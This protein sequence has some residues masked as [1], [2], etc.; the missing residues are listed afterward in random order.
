MKDF[1]KFSSIS[2]LSS[3]VLTSS[4]KKKTNYLNSHHFLV[5]AHFLKL[6]IC[7]ILGQ[8]VF[9]ILKSHFSEFSN[10]GISIFLYFLDY[11]NFYNS[12]HFWINM[13]LK[14]NLQIFRVHELQ[15]HIKFPPLSLPVTKSGLVMLTQSH[16]LQYVIQT[17]KCKT[18]QLNKPSSCLFM[19][20]S[21][22]TR[23]N[24]IHIPERVISE[25]YQDLIDFKFS[26]TFYCIFEFFNSEFSIQAMK[27]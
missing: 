26:Q 11:A 14:L 3:K 22:S 10:F 16:I 24:I 27:P 25:L 15:K 18:C 13:E 1:F 12:E 9:K 4:I 19:R 2:F 21:Y 5:F 17:Q 23:H 6:A 20:K 7:L 8:F